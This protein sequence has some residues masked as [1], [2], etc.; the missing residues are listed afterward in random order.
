VE[1]PS[2]VATGTDMRLRAL[3]PYKNAEQVQ[4]A[5]S[6]AAGTAAN[7]NKRIFMKKFFAFFAVFILAA[8][9]ASA[10]IE[11][12]WGGE[13]IVLIADL[14]D[15]DSYKIDDK[16]VDIGVIYK[17]FKL[18]FIPVIN[19]DK[20]WCLFSGGSYWRYDKT[21]IDKIA[22]EAGITLPAAMK[23]PFWDAWGGKLV[24]LG[25]LAAIVLFAV[26]DV[27]RKKSK[28][29]KNINCPGCG[30]AIKLKNPAGH[31][32]IKC[33]KCG[34]VYDPPLI[35]AIQEYK[36]PLFP[37]KQLYPRHTVFNSVE[38]EPVTGEV[39]IS[40]KYPATFALKNKT[41]GPWYVKTSDGSSFVAQPEDEVP[42]MPGLSIAFAAGV[43]GEI[44]TP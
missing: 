14:P 17:Q 15:N 30:A 22:A 31:N 9:G 44:I 42:I 19:Y 23:L 24:L 36:I 1:T 21:V 16:A 37:G 2:N 40:D 41:P 5:Q 25:I 7:T 4:S 29:E 39:V 28:D 20:R 12:S 34:K 13:K 10:F 32:K 8:Q 18:V 6:L 27:L 33:A 11:F 26:F 3:A 43:Q 35:M 38:S